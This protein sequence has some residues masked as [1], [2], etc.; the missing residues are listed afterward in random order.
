[1]PLLFSEA[2]FSGRYSRVSVQTVG[3]AQL[4]LVSKEWTVAIS[5]VEHDTTYASFNR[6]GGF[7]KTLVDNKNA[8]IHVTG[9]W[10]EEQNPFGERSNLY[11]NT[12]LTL[13]IFPDFVEKEKNFFFP[14]AVIL[15]VTPSSTVRGV[16]MLDFTARSYGFFSVPKY[17]L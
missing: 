17:D 5:G 6:D 11:P 4:N 14:K 16:T 8:D 15:T 12:L 9:F 3:S 10:T 1:M 13:R 2:Y 7:T